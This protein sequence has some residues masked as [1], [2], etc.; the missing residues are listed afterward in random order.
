MIVGL[1]EHTN[2]RGFIPAAVFL[3][4]LALMKRSAG[5]LMFKGRGL[6]LRLLLVHPGGPFRAKKDDR[7]WSIPKGEYDEGE[8]P[9]AVARRE[10]EEELGPAAP[11]GGIIE[12]GELVQPSR[13]R[14]TAFALEGDFDPTALKSNSFELE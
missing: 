3:F 10:F 5:I 6:E 11:A 1:H 13:R 12:L 4:M 14:I 7:A 8:D 2:R 9:L